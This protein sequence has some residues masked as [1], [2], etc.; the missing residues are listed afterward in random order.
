MAEQESFFKH[1]IK[2]HYDRCQGCTTCMRSCPTGAIRIRGGKP[3]VSDN[4]CVDCGQCMK[5][6]PHRAIYIQQD[7]FALTRNYK[8]RVCLVPATFIGQFDEQIRTREIYS[9][10]KKLGFTHIY[11]VEHEVEY[12]VKLYQQY[13][14]KHPETRTFISPYCPAVIRLIQVRF[15]SLVD[16]VIKVRAPFEL[17]SRI[18]VRRLMDE[19]AARDEIGVFYVTPCAAKIAAVKY[20]VSKKESCIAGVINMDFLYNKVQLMLHESDKS[21]QPI[22]HSLSSQDVLWPLAGGEACHF[23]GSQYA[24]DGLQNVLNFLERLEDDA[25]DAEGLVEMRICDQGCVGGVLATNNRFVARKRLEHRAKLFEDR[26]KTRYERYNNPEFCQWIDDQ[27]AIPEIKPRSIYKLD[28][29]FSEAFKMAE[30]MKK[31]EKALP[32]VNCSACGAPSCAAL[33][34]DIVRGDARMDTCIFINRHSQASE[35]AI[36]SIWGDRVRT[37]E[38]NKDK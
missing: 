37:K 22:N 23:K 35:E 1:S 17:A 16:N 28:D 33:A 24:V 19:G 31:I 14:D 2:V 32:G 10:L 21:A 26:P 18:I 34:E 7:D 12:M 20:P 27:M 9:C 6:C 36:R 30:R 8:Y 4:K 29:D 38:I 25:V 13:M 15:P 11:E 3:V 5:V